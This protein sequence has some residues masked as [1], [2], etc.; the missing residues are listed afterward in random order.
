MA[1]S[2]KA[3]VFSLKGVRSMFT[4][5]EGRFYY[6]NGSEL[7]EFRKVGTKCQS[8]KVSEYQLRPCFQ[9]P[10]N[11]PWA[12]SCLY[13]IKCWI[14]LHEESKLRIIGHT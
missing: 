7:E 14:L 6:L 2:L 3:Y 9:K 1:T 12:Q 10:K 4:M 8:L 11:K 13:K 5:I